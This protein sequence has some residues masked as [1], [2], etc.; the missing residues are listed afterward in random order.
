MTSHSGGSRGGPGGLEPPP[1]F[2]PLCLIIWVK[3]GM[4]LPKIVYCKYLDFNRVYFSEVI[5]MIFCFRTHSP[6]FRRSRY[7]FYV[8]MGTVKL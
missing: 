4:D 1:P 5:F 2:W 7:Y 8:F 6:N 3:Y